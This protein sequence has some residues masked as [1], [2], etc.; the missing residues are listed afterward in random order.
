[1]PLQESG[2]EERVRMEA[3]DHP[4]AGKVGTVIDRVPCGAKYQLDAGG[5]EPDLMDV[6]CDCGCDDLIIRLDDGTLTRVYE[7]EVA[8]P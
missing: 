8:T 2:G 5:L 3:A 1:M 6:D 4:H 7:L